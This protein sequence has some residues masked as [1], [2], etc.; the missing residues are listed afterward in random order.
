MK[1]LIKKIRT[2]LA[3]NNFNKLSLRILFSEGH[4]KC[5]VLI[6]D[7]IVDYELSVDD[8]L[9][10]SDTISC[11]KKD[12]DLMDNQLL[13]SIEDGC[14][15]EQ[16]GF[17]ENFYMTTHCSLLNKLKNISM[18]SS[19]IE[20]N[21]F[22]ELLDVAKYAISKIDL[23]EMLSALQDKCNLYIAIENCSILSDIKPNEI[24][25]NKY[26]FLCEVLKE[27][28]QCMDLVKIIVRKIEEHYRISIDK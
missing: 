28:I 3:N 13:I 16:F 24:N 8:A 14:F 7:E 22:S 11:R 5:V 25:A 9:F 15:S 6:D 26:L 19:G 20:R 1:N 18:D 12:Y 21:E 10:I 23:K 2:E 17:N 4:I 27:D